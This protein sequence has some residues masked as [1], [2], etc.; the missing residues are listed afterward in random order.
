MKKT[1]KRNITPEDR[2][3][4]A[5]LRVLWDSKARGERPTQDEMAHRLGGSSQSL[6]SQYLNGKIALN[7]RAVLAFAEALGCAPE[8]IRD[9]LKE[10]LLAR[11]AA[12]SQ[13]VRNEASTLSLRR[14]ELG[15]SHADVHARM[16]ALPWPDGLEPPDLPTVTEWLEGRR[17]PVDMF[18]RGMLYKALGMGTDTDVAME[19]GIAKT[20]VGARLLRLAESGDPELAAHMLAVFEAATQTGRN[21]PSN[22]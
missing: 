20:E 9:D 8:A 11:S 15:L 6:T 5:R 7:Y 4:A 10:Q 1:T 17:R 12:V 22:G 2:A 18:Y 3:A 19:D 14:K 13:S 21:G 16:L